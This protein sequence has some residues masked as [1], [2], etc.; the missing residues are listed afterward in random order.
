LPLHWR[1]VS[2]STLG[3]SGLV[4]LA[5]DDDALQFFKDW[6][7]LIGRVNLRVTLLLRRQESDLLESLQLT[8][9]VTRVFLNELGETADVSMKIRILRVDHYDFS[10]HSTSDK[11]V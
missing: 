4:L 1:Y 3:A 6:E 10:A 2:R 9:Y 7:L 11:N 5:L 8:L